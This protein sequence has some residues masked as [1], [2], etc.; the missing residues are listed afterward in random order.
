[1]AARRLLS[2]SA[3]LR[4]FLEFLQF[5]IIVYKEN[6]TQVEWAVVGREMSLVA[7]YAAVPVEE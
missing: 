5:Y 3:Q 4:E 1:M 2:L 6:S 7:G